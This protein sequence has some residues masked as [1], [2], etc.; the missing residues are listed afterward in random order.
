MNDQKGVLRSTTTIFLLVGLVGIWMGGCEKLT[1]EQ[2][3]E[4]LIKKLQEQDVSVRS[5]KALGQIGTPEALKAVEEYE[6]QQ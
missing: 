5:A 4:K 2:K 3:V 6:F 1:Q